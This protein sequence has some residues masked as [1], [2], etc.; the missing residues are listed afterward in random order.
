MNAVDPLDRPWNLLAES[1]DE[2][3]GRVAVHCAGT[4]HTYGELRRDVA[5]M[6][7]GLAERLAVGER[8]G[9]LVGNRYAYLVADLAILRAGLVKVSLNPALPAA[10]I[11]HVLRHAQVRLL[12]V[13]RRLPVVDGGP[14]GGLTDPVV[15][16]VDGAEYRELLDTPPT[17]P[18]PVGP[19]DP[20]VIYYTGGTT[21]RPKGVV[22]TQRSV[23]TNLVAHVLD[24][25]IRREE[26]L[27][28]STAL[29][30]SAGVFAT[31]ALTRGA[32]LVVL[33]GFDPARLCAAFAE[34][35]ARWTSMVPT[36]LYR[37]LDHLA[38]TG[39][40]PPALDTL[41]YGSAPITPRRLREAVTVFGPV[42]VQL[43]GQTECPNWGTKLTKADHAA[44]LERPALL[45]SA[46][47]RAATAAVRVVD[48][49]GRAVPPGTVG[50]VCLAAPYLMS[51]YHHDPAATAA[52]FTAD[53]WLRTRDIGQVDG[54]GYLFLKDRLADM[55]I[56]GGYNVYSA[57]VEA[58]VAAQPGVRQVAVIGIP[59]D[60][61][62]EAVCALVVPDPAAGLTEEGL[63]AACRA[64]LGG[65]R[66][67][68]VVAFVD[69]IPVT[70]FGKADKK[71][72]RAPWWAGAE[73]SI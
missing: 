9:L 24:G 14:I 44:A 63:R 65:Y 70:P 31:A 33:D 69:D 53:G 57:E 17:A 52:A 13:S 66:A 2:D 51:G 72:L 73:R 10:D 64:A 35:G 21:G 41:V 67:P 23:A 59:D 49:E 38:A 42:L 27:V 8:V 46:G 19:G 71:A 30:H 40:A 62:G 20:A 26:V 16:D 58:V 32:T 39:A 7:A 18:R 47:R 29:S 43:Y 48:G 61:W 22:H 3:P 54:Q 56:S 25:E 6:A 36:M 11:V 50:E 45:G 4:A 68:K 37:L 5:A 1:L 60:D 55:I 34:H 28:L 15:L 12:L